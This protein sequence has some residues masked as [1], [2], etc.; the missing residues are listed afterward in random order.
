M[1]T[2]VS[3]A[4][5]NRDGA[6][7]QGEQCPSLC[8]CRDETVL[9][10]EHVLTEVAPAPAVHRV[11]APTNTLFLL[12]ETSERDECPAERVHQVAGGGRLFV[13]ADQR[14]AAADGEEPG[15]EATLFSRKI[16]NHRRHRAGK[17][18][19]VAI[20]GEEICHNARRVPPGGGGVTSVSSSSIRVV[21]REQTLLS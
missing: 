1:V 4:R 2:A 16:K 10:P 14:P 12:P 8:L 18:W 21:C 7:P 19:A 20:L 13:T 15:G 3:L 9:V 5:G 11:C 6:P 17:R